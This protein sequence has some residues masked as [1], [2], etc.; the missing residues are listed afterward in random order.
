MVN[1]AISIFKNV[2]VKMSCAKG[3]LGN[4]L[5]SVRVKHGLYTME[6]KI[7][8]ERVGCTIQCLKCRLWR[9]GIPNVDCGVKS[10]MCGVS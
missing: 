3:K 10:A 2:E 7:K 6:F 8:S 4:G 5:S 1:C 9:S